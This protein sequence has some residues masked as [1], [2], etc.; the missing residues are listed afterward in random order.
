MSGAPNTKKLRAL[1]RTSDYR[2]VKPGRYVKAGFYVEEKT[3]ERFKAAVKLL[4]FES[5]FAA[6]EALELWLEDN[7]DLLR[8]K[9]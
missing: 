9:K 6:T 5:R 1:A 3:M 2:L 8:S 4:Q 7:A